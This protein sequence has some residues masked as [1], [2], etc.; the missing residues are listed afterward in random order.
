[1]NHVTTIAGAPSFTASSYGVLQWTHS[2]IRRQEIRT[3][4]VVVRNLP[5]LDLVQGRSDSP[6]LQSARIN[7][8]QADA[9]VVVTP[10][11]R[12]AYPG[13]LKAFLDLLP[14]DALSGKVVLPIATGGR[15]RQPSALDQS[16]GPV[17]R[18]LGA[19]RVLEGV[20]ITDRQVHYAHGG[21]LELDEDAEE[22]LQEALH[23][24]IGSIN[25]PEAERTGTAT[26]TTGEY[27]L[28]EAF[29]R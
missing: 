15:L 1:M 10:L 14:P 23:T 3:S 5:A 22:A 25:S 24:L 11:M 8:D 17:L 6:A 12:C 18:S 21:A 4:T 19:S 26:V 13:I 9:V 2:Q 28:L 7:V 29:E 27:E 20:H 16:I